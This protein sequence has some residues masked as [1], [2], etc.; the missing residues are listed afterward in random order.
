MWLF[1]RITDSN[2]LENNKLFSK[3]SC[4]INTSAWIKNQFSLPDSFSSKLTE[5]SEKFSSLPDYARNSGKFM[6]TIG[7]FLTMK[8]PKKQ[9]QQWISCENHFLEDSF[10]CLPLNPQT[11]LSPCFSLFFQR[12]TSQVRLL[13]L[14]HSFRLQQT[15]SFG[16]CHESS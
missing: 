1:P 16:I 11:G 5:Q 10:M 14:K 3:S 15:K 4:R 7:T 2:D 6:N 8:Y 13:T 12:R 9:K